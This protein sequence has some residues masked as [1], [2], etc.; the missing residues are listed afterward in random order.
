VNT[1][2]FAA[3]V[4]T[5]VRGTVL[6]T[7]AGDAGCYDTTVE[8]PPP[9]PRAICSGFCGIYYPVDATEPMDAGAAGV[10]DVGAR[11]GDQG[12]VEDGRR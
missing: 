9:V 10:P 8:S 1:R 11:D 4:L 3:I 2:L 6:A 7:V 12:S 5:A